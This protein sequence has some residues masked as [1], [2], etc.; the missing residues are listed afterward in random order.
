M[1]R[2][3]T[4]RHFAMFALY[5]L[6]ESAQLQYVLM[7][8]PGM[9]IVSLCGK[10]SDGQTGRDAPNNRLQQPNTA[11]SNADD[12]RLSV[13]SHQ[14]ADVRCTSHSADGVSKLPREY[15]FK[16]WDHVKSVSSNGFLP[17][18]PTPYSS[19]HLQAH[20]TP[21]LPAPCPSQLSNLPTPTMTP[22]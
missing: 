12:L 17:V 19:S 1:W 8:D 22:S 3:I 13:L 5:G 20:E 7:S 10:D 21:T 2:N 6:I 11:C 9:P 18:R 15:I 16:M 14:C 4:L